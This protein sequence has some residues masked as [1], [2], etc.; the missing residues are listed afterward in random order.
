MES[1]KHIQAMIPVSAYPSGLAETRINLRIYKK[2]SVENSS[3]E[4]PYF[5][6]SSR[7]VTRWLISAVL[8]EIR[9]N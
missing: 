3:G 6:A 7:S 9:I 4:A 2:A 5:I 8:S 1:G